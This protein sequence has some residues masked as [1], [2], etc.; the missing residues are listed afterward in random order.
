MS[1]LSEA[2]REWAAFVDR[3]PRADELIPSF[4]TFTDGN[5]GIY[6]GPQPGLNPDERIALLQH[7]A[8]YF[9]NLDFPVPVRD[10]YVGEH[11]ARFYEFTSCIGDVNV[12]VTAIVYD[13]ELVTA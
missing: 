8:G 1:K 6:A 2:L 11:L 9:D 10:R 7:L 5:V 12:Y 4:Q 13:H 3:T